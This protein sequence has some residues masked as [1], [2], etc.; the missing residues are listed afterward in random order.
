MEEQDIFFVFIEMETVGTL[1]NP[2]ETGDI[3]CEVSP[4][5]KS[6][7]KYQMVMREE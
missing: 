3:Y 6:I 1:G 7:V 4:E 5:S 2:G